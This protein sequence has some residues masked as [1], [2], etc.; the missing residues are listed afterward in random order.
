MPNETLYR[1]R[2]V[3]G[4]LVLNFG[5][6]SPT[7]ITGIPNADKFGGIV[8]FSNTGGTLVTSGGIPLFSDFTAGGTQFTI[9]PAEM[10][11][12]QFTI[13][14][15]TA[16]G[17]APIQIQPNYAVAGA[18]TSQP[19]AL[20]LPATQIS[21]SYLGNGP[22]LYEPPQNAFMFGTVNA[23]PTGGTA[24]AVI[25]GFTASMIGTTQTM[26][27]TYYNHSV[28]ASTTWYTGPSQQTGWMNANQSLSFVTVPFVWSVQ[29]GLCV[30]TGSTQPAV[31]SLVV[32][33]QKN[34]ADT[35]LVVTIPA[36]G[37]AGIWC[38]NDS[39]HTASGSAGDRIN[40]K[41]Q[42]KDTGTTSA[43]IQSIT[44]G[45]TPASPA[46]GMI[47]FGLGGRTISSNQTNYYAPFGGS[48][49]TLTAA[50]AQVALPR[51]VTIRNLHCWVTSCP[52]TNA[53]FGVYNNGSLG[54]LKVVVIGPGCTLGDNSDTS[55]SDEMTFAQG[56]TIELGESQSL[57][58]TNPSISSCTVEH[59]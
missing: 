49:F 10:W 23:L 41:I 9:N 58:A 3:G 35:T 32:T 8:G 55:T 17:T 27:G 29:G 16:N 25:R 18:P 30:Y 12:G 46:T 39:T 24:Y 44:L 2:Y 54:P 33:L 26:L 48:N 1:K 36:G 6:D 14:T 11:L 59:D 5:I 4:R 53:T 13:N 56:Q 22:P 50:N 34:T 47:I 31:D 52:G 21:G 38:D 40:F 43:T 45:M 20:N 28:P 57:S 19:P 51:A 42:N 7:S 15:S 37:T